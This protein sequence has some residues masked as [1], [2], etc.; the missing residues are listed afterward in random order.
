MVIL[1]ELLLL[2]VVR[3]GGGGDGA[4]VVV[5]FSVGVF[6]VMM[7]VAHLGV[8]LFYFLPQLPR[9]SRVKDSR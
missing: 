9:T 3:G 8:A 6:N 7:F 1:V 5:V 2:F 4:A